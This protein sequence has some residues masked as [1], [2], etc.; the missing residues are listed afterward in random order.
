[1]SETVRYSYSDGAQEVLSRLSVVVVVGDSDVMEREVCLKV[2][3]DEKLLLMGAL[4]NR[5]LDYSDTKTMHKLLWVTDLDEEVCGQLEKMANLE[6]GINEIRD[7][8]DKFVEEELDEEEK[9]RKR[10]AYQEKHSRLFIEDLLKKSLP[11]GV[12]AVKALSV[13]RDKYYLNLWDKW[14]ERGIVGVVFEEVLKDV[15]F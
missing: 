12:S 13:F 15:D 3:K 9:A 5:L 1:M 11:S 10:Q 14:S 4:V 6:G 2:P 7:A 8:A